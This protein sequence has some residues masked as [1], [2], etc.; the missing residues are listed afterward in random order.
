MTNEAS[1]MGCL[2]YLIS[3]H[4]LRTTYTLC[5][6]IMG[7]MQKVRTEWWEGEMEGDGEKTGGKKKKKKRGRLLTRLPS[8]KWLLALIAPG[9]ILHALTNVR[10]FALSAQVRLL[11]LHTSLC[12]CETNYGELQLYWMML[13]MRL[14][15]LLYAQSGVEGVQAGRVRSDR[16]SRQE[17]FAPYPP[18]W[19]I[20]K[21]MNDHIHLLRCP[22]NQAVCPQTTS[23]CIELAAV[24]AFF[25]QSLLSLLS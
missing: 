18:H 17:T 19:W 13:T 7:V 22:L 8:S 16:K 10:V 11:V 14:S 23:V 12:C 9:G 4:V 1:S 25:L 3:H 20:Q 5:S 6:E 24:I 15:V 21:G 2:Y